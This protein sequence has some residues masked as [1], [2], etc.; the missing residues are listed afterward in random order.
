MRPASLDQ[1]L[2]FFFRVDGRIGRV[3][4]ALGFGC[5]YAVNL[6]ILAFVLVRDNDLTPATW[7]FLVI[8]SLPLVMGFL[9]IMAKRC[10]DLGLPGSFLLLAFVPFVGLVWPFVLAVLPGNP[11]ANRYGTPPA[12][13][14]E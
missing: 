5:I 4:F 8:L 7:L 3:E 11:G 6:A 14:Q 12:F 13:D 1:I 9:V 2:R 10:H